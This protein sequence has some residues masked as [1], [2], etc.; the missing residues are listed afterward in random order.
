MDVTPVQ[1]ATSNG[2]MRRNI[3]VLNKGTSLPETDVKAT[4]TGSLQ[5]GATALQTIQFKKKS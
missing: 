2:Y 4:Y 1:K 3:Y 5:E